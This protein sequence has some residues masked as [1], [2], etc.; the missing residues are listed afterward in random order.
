MSGYQQIQ[1]E[2]NKLWSVERPMVV[3]QVTEAAEQGDRSENAAYIYGKKRLRQI[4]G[5]LRYLK[6]KIANVN[7]IDIS[8]Q[9]QHS[10]VKFGALVQ[11]ENDDGERFEWRLVDREESEPKAGRISVQ[12]PMGRALLGRVVGDLVE[13]S[14]PSGK[15]GFEVLSIKFGVE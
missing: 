10:D 3:Q 9:V 8:K 6:K 11:V 15:R 13:V 1:K 12:S 7:V 4:D 2:I 14:L 5:R